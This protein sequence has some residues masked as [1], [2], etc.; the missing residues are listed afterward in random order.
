[1]RI[2]ELTWEVRD[3]NLNRVGQLLPADLVG[4]KSVLRFNNV[5]TWEIVLPG[6]HTL[7][8]ALSTPGAGIIV[9]HRDSGVILSGPTTAVEKVTET[10]NPVGAV[11]ISGVDDS[12]ILAERLAYPTPSTDDVTAQTQAHDIEDNVPSSTAMFGFVRRNLITGVAPAVRAV[13]H[14]ALG[15]DLALGSTIRKSARFDILGELLS[16]IAIVDGL[17]FDI[18]QQDDALV[19]NVFEPVDRSQEIRMDVENNT[20]ASTSFG[21]GLPGLTKAIVAG[22]GDL[23]ERTF[24]QVETVEADQAEDVWNRRIERFIDQ[25]NTNDLTELTQA[26]LEAL[27]ESGSTLT[28]IDVIP[29][30]D[31]TMAYG[32]DWNLGDRVTVVVG[33]EE[34]SATVTQVAISVEGDGMRVG[35]TVGQPNGVDYDSQLARQQTTTVKRVNALERVESSST[36]GGSDFGNLDNGTPSTVFGG[37]DPID[38]GGV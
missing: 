34:I 12:A 21:Y 29:S 35:A 8:K 5:G 33:E 14:L 11:K 22:Q 18:K 26:G 2:D 17:G 13:P 32:V 38:A 3:E 36:A 37:S 6:D 7:G 16:E 23:T 27:A 4:W 10:A 9:T 24:V 30:S 20:L 1:M 31:L 28:S 19:F 25:R 15:T